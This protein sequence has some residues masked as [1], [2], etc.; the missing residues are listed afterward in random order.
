MTERPLTLRGDSRG[1]LVVTCE[2]ATPRVPDRLGDLGLTDDQRRDHI[3]WDIGAAWVVEAL[4]ERLAAPA[5][6]SSVSRLVVDCNRDPGDDD[7]IPEISHGVLIPA[8]RRV[9]D[10]ERARRLGDY[11]DPFHAEVDRLLALSD[12]AVLLS[13]HSFT[14]AYDGREFD[15]GVLFDDCAAHAQRLA[16]DLDRSGFAVRMNEPYSGLD[17][18]IFSARSHG[19]RFQR[20]YLEIEINNRLVRTPAGARTVAVGIAAAAARFVAPR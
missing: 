6:L 3:G 8:N 17:G 12:D 5:V 19:R 7:W 10:A 18:L 13:I 15:I 20:A 9:D 16:H 11:Y 4:S 2:H 1:G 14:P